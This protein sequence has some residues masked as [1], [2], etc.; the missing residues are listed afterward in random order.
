[1]LRMAWNCRT[2]CSYG[3]V[4]GQR[5]FTSCFLLYW[6]SPAAYFLHSN[7]VQD[8]PVVSDKSVRPSGHARAGMQSLG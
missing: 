8:A 5:V 1:M 4:G 2:P 7:G 6:D 3:A